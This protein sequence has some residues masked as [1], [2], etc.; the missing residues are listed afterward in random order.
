[1]EVLTSFFQ[2]LMSMSMEMSSWKCREK[3]EERKGDEGE[4]DVS[5]KC[6][7]M[8]LLARKERQITK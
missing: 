2:S 7:G 5:S 8:P 6:L 1:M 4:R 3:E